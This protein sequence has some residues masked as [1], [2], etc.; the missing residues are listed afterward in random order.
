MSDAQI[1][2]MAADLERLREALEEIDMRAKQYDAEDMADIARNALNG[3]TVADYDARA[4]APQWQPIELAPKD[5][6][7][8]WASYDGD[9]ISVRWHDTFESFVSSW[10]EMTFAENYGGGTKLHSPTTHAPAYWM[11][12]IAPPAKKGGGA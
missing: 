11:P 6:T 3:G 4:D 9:A 8:F 12:R 7:W 2:N 1:K 5:G 10:R